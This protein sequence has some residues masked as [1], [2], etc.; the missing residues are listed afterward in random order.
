MI[1]ITCTRDQCGLDQLRSVHRTC[2]K[3]IKYAYKFN[4]QQKFAYGTRAT[5]NV[6]KSSNLIGQLGHLVEGTNIA[7]DSLYRQVEL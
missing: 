1:N 4:I 6:T 2:H 7:V 3:D 5:T